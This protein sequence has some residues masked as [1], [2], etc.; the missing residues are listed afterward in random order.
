MTLYLGRLQVNA[1]TATVPTMKKELDR[2][3]R[4]RGFD[5]VLDMSNLGLE[6]EVKRNKK[7]KEKGNGKGKGK[8]RKRV[9]R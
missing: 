1:P 7:E 3:S 2:H 5:L 9:K 4:P 6:F 8:E